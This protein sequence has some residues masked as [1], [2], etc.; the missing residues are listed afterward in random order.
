MGEAWKIIFERYIECYGAI[1]TL[2]WNGIFDEEEKTTHEHN[3]MVQIIETM[4]REIG[5]V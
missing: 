4:K 3:L 5:D 1:Q 2:F